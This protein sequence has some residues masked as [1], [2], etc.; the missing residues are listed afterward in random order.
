MILVDSINEGIA[1]TK[2]LCTKLSDNLN[3]KA[4]QMIQCCH[5]NLSDKSKKLFTEDFF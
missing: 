2:Y 4:K 1:L 5:L 3:D